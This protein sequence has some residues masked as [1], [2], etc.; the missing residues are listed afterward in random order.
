MSEPSRRLLPY[1]SVFS[2]PMLASLLLVC[3]LT[4]GCS[5]KDT[6]AAGGPPSFPPL[7]VQVAEV[8]TATLSVDVQTVGSLRS[9]ETTIVSSDEAGILTYLDAPE[10]RP[11]QRGHLI[12]RID[13][14]EAKAAI[15]VAEAR[16]TNAEAALKRIRPLFEQG[17]VSQQAIDNAVAEQ[18]TA[19]G[20]L[21]EARTNL[22][23]TRIVA[24]FSGVVG[25]QTA[26][27]GQ[28]VSS[29]QAIV[30]LT[31][32]DPLELIFNLP[33]EEAPRVEIGQTVFGRVGRC[34]DKFEGTVEAIDPSLDPMTRTLAVQAKVDNKDRRLRPGMSAR[35]RL[36][37]GQKEGSLVIPREALT[38]QGSRYIVF[39]VADGQ[40][41]TPAEGK[42][43]SQ[44]R[45]VTVGRY[46][47]E[48]VEITAGLAPGDQVIA[49][50][51]QKARPGAPIQPTPWVPTE[52][53]NLELGQSPT[54]DDC[55][56]S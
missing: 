29:G 44:P 15:T 35:V 21:E 45:P 37:V 16:Y 4:L 26:Q 52:N 48:G 38:A 30:Q 3:G 46:L 28:Y 55:A 22:G 51:H 14:A 25:L 42:K 5:G 7:P 53:Q 24:P 31:R 10:G 50:G 2:L 9:P 20:L 39:V 18:N 17:V 32:V 13:D 27:R 49:A 19:E 40:P 33:E 56:D 1:D 54:G 36:E 41:G 8:Q 11:V 6:H 43:I 34:G 23:K 47:T 12:A